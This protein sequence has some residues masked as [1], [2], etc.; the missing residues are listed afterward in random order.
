MLYAINQTTLV[1]WY[2]N[3]VRRDEIRLLMQG[4]SPPQPQFTTDPNSLPPAKGLLSGPGP[5]PLNPHIFPE[6][7]DTT[8]QARV[9][10]RKDTTGTLAG[11]AVSLTASTG[12]INAHDLLNPSSLSSVPGR[13][14]GCWSFPACHL[15]LVPLVYHLLLIPLVLHHA[16][17]HGEES[18]RG[19]KAK[20]QGREGNTPAEFVED[21]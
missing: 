13:I 5:S 18:G 15:L 8:G 7:E 1:R 16:P 11:S 19:N 4:L 3:N 21:R 6:A 20:D 10:K 12:T 14:I 9:R 2:K 17:Q